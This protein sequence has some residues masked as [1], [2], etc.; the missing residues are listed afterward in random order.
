MPETNPP[1]NEPTPVT[2][3]PIRVGENDRPGP[4]RPRTVPPVPPLP[5]DGYC[6]FTAGVVGAGKSTLQHALIH[7]LYTDERI[8]LTFQNEDGETSP[9][10]EL[11]GWINRF[12]RGEFP[13]RTPQGTL[14]TF[15]IEFGRRRRPV[16]LSF[17]EISGE[18]FLAILPRKDR[19]DYEPRLPS[20]LEHVLTAKGIRKLF[21]FVADTT[22]HDPAK[23]PNRSSDDRDQR[24]FED[25]VFSELLIHILDLGLNRIR[26]LFVAAKWDAAPNRN[27][28][29]KR[30]FGQHF[31]QTKSALRRFEKAQV[32]YIRFTVGNVQN[33]GDETAGVAQ[34]PIVGKHDFLPISRV[35]Q[36]IHTHATERSLPGYPPVRMTL[37]QKI[38]RWAATT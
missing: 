32:Q 38:K 17:V 20:E 22:R 23:A 1:P 8:D 12:D 16:K 5:Q 35:I 11:L 25:M 14:Q 7:R 37:W 34:T 29:P 18:D 31:P 15:F 13:E 28:D 33:T 10:G 24:L 9:N 21:I 4:D 2:I 6:L 3:R 30:F 36:W 27:L 26:L 19:P